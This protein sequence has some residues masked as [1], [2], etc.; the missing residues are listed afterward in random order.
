MRGGAEEAELS[1]GGGALQRR[2]SSPE[3]EELSRGGG[4]LQTLR[5]EMQLEAEISVDDKHKMA[6]VRAVMENVFVGE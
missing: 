5:E 6:V 3:E 1:R 4:A 2:R